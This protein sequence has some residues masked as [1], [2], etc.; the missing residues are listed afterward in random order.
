M[1]LDLIA[2]LMVEGTISKNRYFWHRDSDPYALFVAEFFL[3]RSNRTTVERFLP[4]FL[5]RFPSPEALSRADPDTVVAAANWAGLRNRTSHLPKVISMY[6]SRDDWT[7]SGLKALPYIGDYAAAAIALYVLGETA[8]PIDNNVRR[9]VGR[10]LGAN[11]EY[12][13]ERAADALRLSASSRGGIE[14]L[15]LTHLGILAVGWHS[16][17]QRPKCSTCPLTGSCDWSQSS[18]RCP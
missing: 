12:E 4:D 14:G 11:T 3:R 6:A 10:Y 16:C 13:F 7:E 1:I 5:S 17:R 15:Q 2:L 9:V 18:R 8:F